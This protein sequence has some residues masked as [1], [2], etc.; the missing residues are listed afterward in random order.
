MGFRDI[1]RSAGA[2]CMAV[3]VAILLA[4][5]TGCKSKYVEA[6]VENGNSAAVS[7]VELDYPSASFGVETL[8][9]GATYHYR[10]KILGSGPTKVLWTDAAQH[11]HSVAG[12]KLDEGQEGTLMVTLAGDS[13]TWSKELRP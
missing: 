7:L 3:A 11:D 4:G 9:A 12:P 6:D 13:A 10:F 5:T 1:K 8:A 2:G